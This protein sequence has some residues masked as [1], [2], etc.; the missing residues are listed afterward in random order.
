MVMAVI[1]RE[2]FVT[3]L[4]S[5]LESEGK[6]FSATMSGKIK[7][8]VQCAAVVGS[9]LFLEYGADAAAKPS[10]EIALKVLLWSASRD[11]ALQWLRVRHSSGEVIQERVRR[12]S[13]KSVDMCGHPG[14]L[15]IR[16]HTG[17]QFRSFGCRP[18]LVL[19]ASLAAIGASAA[20]DDVPLRHREPN[21]SP[22][23]G[24]AHRRNRFRSQPRADTRNRKTG[25]RE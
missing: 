15:A 6:D 11:H 10:L 8:V 3:S 17:L 20:D 19:A 25:R 7:M 2:M 23:L 13:Q 18:M 5:V 24:R 21:R 12:K 22:H 9:L 14:E 16:P 4:R 1:G